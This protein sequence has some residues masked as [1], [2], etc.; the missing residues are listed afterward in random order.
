[1]RRSSSPKR[2]G[3]PPHHLWTKEAKKRRIETPEDDRGV[4]L[5]D[6]LIDRVKD[7]VKEPWD[8]RG[9]LD[10]HHFYWP[11]SIYPHNPFDKA[12]NPSTF[13]NISIHKGLVPRPFHDYLHRVTVPPPQPS[14]E[15][16]GYRIEA[17]NVV[18]N[19]FELTRNS[20]HR[21]R[22]QKPFLY[23][24]GDLELPKNNETYSEDIGEEI[25]KE[26]LAHKFSDYETR[27]R[28]VQA[29]PD[30][31][32][33]IDVNERDGSIQLIA[34]RLGQL[35]GGKSLNLAPAIVT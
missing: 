17:Y 34:T 28:Q 13:R 7:S 31:F 5:I 10:V 24:H 23:R 21:H 25:M 33:L 15:I 32:K 8:W 9:N 18:K 4:V 2:G 11:K 22:I 20:V 26:I 35:V 14:K 29:I 16:M 27:L 1:M 6:E 30:E 12:A 3:L 19:L